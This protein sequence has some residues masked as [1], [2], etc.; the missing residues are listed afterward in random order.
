MNDLRQ[1]K[2]A[3]EVQKILNRLQSVSF[4]ADPHLEMRVLARL[5]ERRKKKL[6]FY[7]WRN[8]AIGGFTCSAAMVALLLIVLFRTTEY[9][10]FVYQ[11]FVVR[12]EVSDLKKVVIARAQIELPEGVYFDIDE[13]P[14]LRNQRL[15][16]VYWKNQGENHLFPMVLKATEEGTKAVLIRFF[17][18]H[19]AV[20]AEKVVSIKLIRNV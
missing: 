20:V 18:E 15:L 3:E 8:L 7:W 4:Q 1:K 16:T 2:E 5:G 14:E 19:N 10:A 9:E 11:P 6:L 17:D 13:Y 12:I